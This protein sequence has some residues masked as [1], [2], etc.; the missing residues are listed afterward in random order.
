MPERVAVFLD[1][2]NIYRAFRAAFGATRYAPLKLASD[3]TGNRQ[4]IRVTFY[5]AAVPQQMGVQLYADQQ[6]FLTRLK[7]GGD[8]VCRRL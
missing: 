7:G 5:I 2:A 3:L 1:G 4:L 6:R 8:G